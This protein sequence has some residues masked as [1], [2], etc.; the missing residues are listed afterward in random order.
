MRSQQ[1]VD[2]D[3][4]VRKPRLTTTPKQTELINHIRSGKYLYLAM[5]GGIRGTKT[6]GF[7]IAIVLL[8]R[9]FPGSRWAIVRKDL[10]TLRRNTLPSFNKIKDLTGGFVGDM[11]QSDW[12]ARC[13]NGSQILFFAESFAIDPE[14][15]RWKGLEVNGFLLEEASELNVA[16]KDKAI[17]RAGSWIIPGNDR[18]PEP[19]QPPP[20][21]FFSFNPCANWP[22]AVF[23]E[24]SKLGTLAPPFFYLPA[25]AADNP[26][27]PDAVRE[28]WKNLPP[29]LYARFV[30]GEWNFT[31]DPDQLIKYEWIDAAFNRDP[32]IGLI[33]NRAGADIARYGDD[34][35][36]F[37]GIEGTCLRYIEE[38]DQLSVD[39]VSDKLIK[40]C[41]QRSF[42]VDGNRVKVDGVGIGAGV[43]DLCRK[44]KFPV[45][46][47][48][49]GAK[50]IERKKTPMGP[51]TSIVKFRNIRSQMWWEFAEQLR[52]G[53]DISFASTF[54]DSQR[55]KL[56]SDLTAV[57]YTIDGEKMITIEPKDDI[58]KRIGRSTD[59]ADAVVQAYFDMSNNRPKAT[60]VMPV[61]TGVTSPFSA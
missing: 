52:L 29:N 5:G 32:Q 37:A 15:E 17:E 8:C 58:K 30:L 41:N 48:I 43:V 36:V 12:I 3:T 53:V 16:S 4:A 20:F 44:S 46:D 50:P 45:L 11:N 55:A 10:A 42:Y 38:H 51:P 25:T 1:Q 19:K 61:S 9:M 2:L 18:D 28:A 27:I 54:T 6:F 22:R 57:H 56:V 39:E 34:K 14:Q 26:F 59:Y 49:A 35:T 31:E 7:L 40:F 33:G 24:P 23:Y 60:S 21:V 47:L 13:K